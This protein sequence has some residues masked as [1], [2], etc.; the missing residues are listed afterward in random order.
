MTPSHK[1]KRSTKSNGLR[2]LLLQISI[3]TI[4]NSL[5]T[6]SITQKRKE[7][8]IKTKRERK[9]LTDN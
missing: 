2:K 7:M 9:F 1:N 6:K 8:K 4:E 5:F 3:Q